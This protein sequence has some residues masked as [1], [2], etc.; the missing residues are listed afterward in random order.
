MEAHVFGAVD[1]FEDGGGGLVVVFVEGF[2]AEDAGVAARAVEVASADGGEE[3]VEV[4]EGILWMFSGGKSEGVDVGRSG[5]P[6]MNG[7]GLLD[8]EGDGERTK[9]ISCAFRRVADVFFL[10]RVTSFS[11]RRW[12]SLALGQVVLIDSWVKRDVTRL[13]R[14]A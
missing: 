12:A 13:R 11:A 3:V 4:V 2:D 6:I 10:P 8:L 9:N 1:E 7:R 5:Y 14:R